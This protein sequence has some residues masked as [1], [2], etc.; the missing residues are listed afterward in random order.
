[1]AKTNDGIIMLLDAVYFNN[2]KIGLITEDGI[3][4][5]GDA[6]EYIKVFAAQVRKAPVKKIKVK[7]ATN[8][9]TFTMFEM[10]PQNCA[11][12][13][14][15]EVSGNNWNAPSESV[16]FEGPLSIQC[17][18]GQTISVK[19]VA[20]DGAVR[21]GLG[22]ENKLGIECSMEVLTPDD[23]GSPFSI[24]ETT[25]SIKV[26]G[27]S[28]N[29]DKAGGTK[30]ALLEASGPFRVGAV[31]EGFSIEV[32]RSGLVTVTAVTNEGEQRNGSIEFTLADGSG[33]NCTLSLTQEAG[34]V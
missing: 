24:G 17:G 11:D 10:I 9:F 32:E 30:T 29:F 33:N 13:L 16:S 19:N 25:P 14:G 34:N 20:F 27:T 28:L 6:A 15:G 31:P 5:G 18:T 3:E 7:D 8:L 21:G 1:M 22:G 12:L 2:K 23:G 26:T 4:W